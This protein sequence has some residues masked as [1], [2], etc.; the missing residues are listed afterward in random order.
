MSLHWIILL[1]Q[2]YHW[3]G[4]PFHLSYNSL[5]N[6]SPPQGAVIVMA[7]IWRERAKLLVLAKTYEDSV[8][9]LQSVPIF[10]K[11]CYSWSRG[12]MRMNGYIKNIVIFV[13]SRMGQ[14]SSRKKQVGSSWSIPQ[15]LAD[16]WWYRDKDRKKKY[17][18]PSQ[19]GTRILV[20]H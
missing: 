19:N 17:W 2:Q 15:F 6:P 13:I 10:A 7:E 8:L 3:K 14:S 9:F 16:H 20:G 18:D 1:K 12:E 11:F 4:C 5:N